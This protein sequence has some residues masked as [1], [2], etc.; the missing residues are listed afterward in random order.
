MDVP[1]PLITSNLVSPTFAEGTFKK[2]DETNIHNTSHLRAESKI[3][4][5]N[6]MN[7]STESF[8]S[9]G[10]NNVKFSRFSSQKA[11]RF[12]HSG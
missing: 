12:G 3:E 2:G 7:Q 8:N 4:L 5:S 11:N 1:D 9:I 6:P 10:A